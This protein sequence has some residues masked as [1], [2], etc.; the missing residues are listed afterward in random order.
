MTSHLPQSAPRGYATGVLYYALL[1]EINGRIKD[2]KYGQRKET[3][4]TG[5]PDRL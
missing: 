3:F 1:A 2:E 4:C 5:N